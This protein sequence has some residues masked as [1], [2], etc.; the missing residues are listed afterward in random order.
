M[1][2][3]WEDWLFEAQGAKFS[4]YGINL[5]SLKSILQSKET[6]K[7]IE[8]YIKNSKDDDEQDEPI[9]EEDIEMYKERFVKD[10]KLIA[11]ELNS[12]LNGIFVLNLEWDGDDEFMLPEN[13]NLNSNNDAWLKM[14]NDVHKSTI[15]FGKSKYPIRE[16]KTA[17][18]I[19]T[20]VKPNKNPQ[21]HFMLVHFPWTTTVDYAMIAKKETFEIIQIL[22]SV[23]IEKAEKAM[24]TDLINP[25]SPKKLK[26]NL[27]TA[28]AAKRYGLL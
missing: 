2:K 4:C 22:S 18:S 6:V 16:L 5:E 25:M 13:S 3:N 27:K 12:T 20:L 9:D 19:I 15:N 28:T 8:S 11:K 23:N 21:T 26:D 24:S 10:L 1:I 14:I 17:W 7:N